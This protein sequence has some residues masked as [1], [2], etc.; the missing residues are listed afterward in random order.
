[1]NLC[2]HLSAT[3][4]RLPDQT[5]VVFEGQQFSYAQL[6]RLSAS[7]AAALSAAGIEVGD[8]VA[9][10]LPNVPSFVVWYYGA[11]RI[12]AIAVSVSTRLMEQEVGLSSRIAR[13]RPLSA[14]QN[15][16]RWTCPIVWW[17]DL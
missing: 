13:R 2:E 3:A 7:A 8:R 5:A 10:M 15:Q 9:I 1:M 16:M 11:L 14:R 4:Q 6:D 17:H 12:G